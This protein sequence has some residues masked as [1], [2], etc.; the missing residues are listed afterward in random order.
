VAVSDKKL[1]EKVRAAVNPSQKGKTSPTEIDVRPRFGYL[2]GHLWKLGTPTTNSD[3]QKR[4][5]EASRPTA[6]GKVLI[7]YYERHPELFRKS[8]WVKT[9]LADAPHMR[10]HLEK[11]KAKTLTRREINALLTR[12]RQQQS[13]VDWSTL[14]DE[15]EKCARL[16]WQCNISVSMIAR[17]LGKHRKTVDELLDRAKAKLD[18]ARNF[19]QRRK[20]QAVTKHG[21]AS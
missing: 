6:K 16:R 18:H 3:Y 12:A 14:T 15:Q 10:G 4:Y 13:P 2:A 9:A 7:E 17:S 20:K 8:A 1:V 19:G 5:N 11:K 21:I